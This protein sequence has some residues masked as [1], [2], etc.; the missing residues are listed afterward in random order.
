MINSNAHIGVGVVGMSWT[1]PAAHAGHA[2]R[3]I[4]PERKRR[5]AIATVASVNR[6]R[7]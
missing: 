2:A 1:V 5:T 7:T 6:G 3:A 4:A